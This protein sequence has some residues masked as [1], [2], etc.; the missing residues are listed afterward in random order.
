VDVFQRI[1][2]NGDQVRQPSRRDHAAVGDS[3]Q[4]GCVHR[5]G[6]DRVD[7][8]HTVPHVDPELAGFLAVG[9]DGRVGAERDLN[10]G[11]DRLAVAL[12]RQRHGFASLSRDQRRHSIVLELGQQIGG[13]HQVGARLLHQGDG[14]VIQHRTVLDRG[15]ARPDGGLDSFGAVGMSR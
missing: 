7:R 3:E 9:I 11:F 6:A 10:A 15:D 8:L 2:G 13:G 4:V 14:L 5:W 12:L 1:A